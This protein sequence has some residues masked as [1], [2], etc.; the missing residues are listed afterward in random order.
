[1]NPRTL[2]GTVT[3]DLRAISN[4]FLLLDDA[5]IF[6]LWDVLAPIDAPDNINTGQTVHLKGFTTKDGPTIETQQ[7]QN[8]SYRDYPI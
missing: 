4:A 5:Y 8:C 1:M 6:V 7:F 2:Y 3:G